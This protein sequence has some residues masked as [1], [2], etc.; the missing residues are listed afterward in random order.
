MQK[1]TYEKHI[2]D[3]PDFPFFFHSGMQAPAYCPDLLH[4]HE[5]IELLYV[6]RGTIRVMCGEAVVTAQAGELVIV[7]PTPCTTSCARGTS[8][9]D[10]TA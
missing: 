1:Q 4:W 10:T 2:H 6:L 7:P 8:R 3:D 5:S 9:R